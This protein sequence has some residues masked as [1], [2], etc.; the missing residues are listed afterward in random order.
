LSRIEKLKIISK[1]SIGKT[2]VY[3]L[4][5]EDNHNFIANGVVAHNS[6]ARKFCMEAKP[7]SI[8]DLAA[9][10]SIYRPGPLKANVHKKYVRAKAN[11]ETITYDHPVI[12]EILGKTYGFLVFQEQFMLL[13]QKMSGFSLGEADKMRKI[14]VK[15]SLDSNAEK[16]IEKVKI[17]ERFIK[18]A[19]ELHGIDPSVSRKIWDVDI[20]GFLSYGFNAAHGTSYAID[21]YYAAWL[22]TYYEKE[23]LATCLQMKMGNPV[24]M[25]KMI[26]EVKQLGYEILPPD[27]NFSGTVWEYSEDR[28]GFVPPLSS[29]KGLGDKAVDEIMT[30]R[31]YRDLDDLLFD[32][33]GNWKHS[34]MNKTCLTS[35]CKVEALES[36]EDLKNRDL[37]NHNQ[38]M[39]LIVDNY[40]ALRK[41]RY[42]M[43]KT[44][45]KR[46]RK[47][48]EEP[49]DILEALIPKYRASIRDWDRIQ[50]LEMQY[51]LIQ[52][53]TPDLLFPEKILDRLRGAEVPPVTT[54]EGRQ[55]AVSW[56]C[57]LEVIRKK[58]RNGKD[59]VRIKVTDEDS[60]TAWLRIW[61]RADKIKPFS[62][63][64]AEVNSDP[65]WGCS[66]NISKLRP[67]IVE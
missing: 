22:M 4:T 44:Q 27:I 38:I 53:A 19:Q 42:G 11:P 49:E 65:D 35:L 36:L 50:K 60:N 43:T 46:I 41:G 28:R 62:I 17:R 67:L 54:L 12:E 55:K 18:G 13:A 14:L 51:D 59:F 10:T 3:D 24:K 32:S 52:M 2:R 23:W 6:G 26:S 15:K 64:L 8:T 57:A 34:K 16:Q 21:S 39:C 7:E 25:A 66:T 30:N 9:I 47:N 58:S 1:K 48:G 61:G 56:F 33:E 29:I 5:V 31:P 20:A 40:N 63:W 37:T 45:V